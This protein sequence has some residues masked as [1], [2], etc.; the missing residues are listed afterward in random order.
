MRIN[1]LN[2]CRA[3][4]LSAIVLVAGISASPSYASTDPALTLKD[5]I[6]QTLERNPQLYQ[7]T[8]AT[9][10][11]EARKTITKLSKDLAAQKKE[12]LYCQNQIQN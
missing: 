4:C 8:L 10:I 2:R 3:I 11:F 7:Y 1:P 5:A 6:A 9:E 12:S